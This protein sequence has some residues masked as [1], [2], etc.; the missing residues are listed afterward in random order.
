LDPLT[1]ILESRE[2]ALLQNL[3]KRDI[4]DTYLHAHAM[5]KAD[6][7]QGGGLSTVGERRWVQ[8]LRKGLG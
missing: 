8:E 4:V 7:T 5:A 3:Q 2:L 6:H 1:F